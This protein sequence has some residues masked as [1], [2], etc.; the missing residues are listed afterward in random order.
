[1][2]TKAKKCGF[3]VY[4]P[5]DVS[6]PIRREPFKGKAP[7]YQT[8]RDAVGGLIQPIK[9]KYE[10]RAR[11]AYV[12]EE[13][14]IRGLPINR[15]FTRMAHEFYGSDTQDFFG[16]AV[17]ILWVTEAPPL[18]QSGPN[19]TDGA[20][21][22]QNAVAEATASRAPDCFKGRLSAWMAKHL[23]GHNI[24]DHVKLSDAFVA[25][26]HVAPEWR[27]YSQGEMARMIGDRGKGGSLG[28]GKDSRYAPDYM[29]AEHYARTLAAFE[30]W[31]S[32]LGFRFRSALEA[33]EK[34]GY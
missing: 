27:H 26:F 14:I 5:A 23:D 29:I 32:G 24:S 21:A 28:G 19:T 6:K 8:L 18:G 16:D 34:A 31:Q 15:R 20:I 11:N 30:P 3:L 10:G 2:A 17:I 9:A 1:M 33:L 7:E 12:N 13:G 22:A 4:V 25:E